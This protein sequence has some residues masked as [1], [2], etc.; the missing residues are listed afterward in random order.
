LRNSRFQASILKLAYRQENREGCDQ[1]RRAADH[2]P[3]ESCAELGHLGDRPI[4]DNR[5]HV[6]YGLLVPSMAAK[7][8]SG[9]SREA[10]IAAT[11]CIPPLSSARGEPCSFLCVGHDNGEVGTMAWKFTIDHDDLTLA[12]AALVSALAISLALI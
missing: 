7:S 5:T 4:Q 12:V 10:T 2:H 9:A 8:R 3:E 6:D 1:E 11:M